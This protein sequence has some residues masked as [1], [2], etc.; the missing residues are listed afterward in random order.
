MSLIYGGRLF[1]GGPYPPLE[2]PLG[3]FPNIQID[4]AVMSVFLFLFLIAAFLHLFLFFANIVRGHRFII[5]A[6][7]FVFCLERVF[8]LAIR[9]AGT[10]RGEDGNLYVGGVVLVFGFTPLLYIINLV[11]AHRIIKAQHPRHG[12]NI[13]ISLVFWLTYLLILFAWACLVAGLV[14]PFFQLST[15]WRY[16]DRGLRIWGFTFFAI[17]SLI[18]LPLVLLSTVIP[19]RHRVNKFGSGSFYAKLWILVLV[20]IL[21]S[22]EAFYIAGVEWVTPTS[23]FVPIPAYMTRTWY[24]V[25]IFTL[26]F[27]IVILYAGA[28]VDRRFH[29]GDQPNNNHTGGA[30]H[31][32]PSYG[33]G[34]PLPPMAAGAQ[35]PMGPTGPMGGMGGL[36]GLGAA[37]A[38]SPKRKRR[39]PGLGK[40]AL[41]GGAGAAAGGILGRR[42]LSKNRDKEADMERDES[43]EPQAVNYPNDPLNAHPIHKEVR[44]FDVETIPEDTE[45]EDSLY[46]AGSSIGTESKRHS[47]V[48]AQEV[49]IGGEHELAQAG[50]AHADRRQGVAL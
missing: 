18:P 8:A 1:Q 27:I 43:P 42:R 10:L 49:E 40:L 26:E 2:W 48:S 20:V 36:G 7:I 25:M 31:P 17:V 11:F 9:I 5:S 38:N 47:G 28:R 19:R 35:P 39:F 45:S 21:T 16:V 13:G 22:L 14:Q 33:P 44:G 23:R 50:N 29:S 3:G 46:A 4:V 24:Y 30:Y 32:G 41:A 6:L 12:G 34:G 15:Y 37:R